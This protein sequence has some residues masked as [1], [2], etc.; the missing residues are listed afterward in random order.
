M[1]EEF[2]FDLRIA[3][4]KS[5]LTQADCG[6]L[7]GV[8]SN[9]I[10]QIELGERTPTAREIC[11]LSVIYGASFESFYSEN[12]QLVRSV[13]SENLDS[14]P[15]APE[16]WLAIESRT[17]TLVYLSDYLGADLPEIL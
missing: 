6:H 7:M 11:A 17:R 4:K 16:G 10:S 14:M 8:S 9:I 3:R 15:D 12:M 2:L 1:F 5:G 13:M